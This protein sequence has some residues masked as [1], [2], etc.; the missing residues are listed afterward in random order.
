MAKVHLFIICAL[1]ITK[2]LGLRSSHAF[3]QLEINLLFWS[4][5]LKC[6]PPPIL[7]V[8]DDFS[9]GSHDV[10]DH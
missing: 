7:T 8:F 1:Y 2:L 3:E 10:I 4:S 6:S 9:A 5:R